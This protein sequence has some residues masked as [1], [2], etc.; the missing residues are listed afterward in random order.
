M[1]R[2]PPSGVGFWRTNWRMSS[3]KAA[4]R[5]RVQRA[6]GPTALGPPTPDCAPSDEGV[7]GWQFLFK[8]N[9][10]EL[11][12][13]EAAKVSKL[14]KG[15]TLDIHGFASQEGPAGFNV[16]LSCHRANRIAELI[17]TTRPD[18]PVKG[19]FKHGASPVSGPGL[20]PDVNPP[21]F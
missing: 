9:C 18:C 15:S 14:K 4:R 8:V 2:A 19:T 1:H 6:C 7:V 5:P 20:V 13:G 10:D 21:D 11:L 12:P 3:S 16:D 17:R